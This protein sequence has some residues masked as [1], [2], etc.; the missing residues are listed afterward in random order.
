MFI[1]R[2]FNIFAFKA[3][4][5][6]LVCVKDLQKGFVDVRLALEAVFDLVDVVYGVV[7]LDRLVVLYGWTGGGPAPWWVE[8]QWR[9]ARRS[10]RRDGRI[11]L[12][13]R[14]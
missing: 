13:A 5:V 2:C 11:A 1:C 3:P 12:A 8:L 6:D 10:V 14:R 7:E 9:R 4:G